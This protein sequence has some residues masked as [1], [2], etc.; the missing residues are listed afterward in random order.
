[1]SLLD[2]VLS[3]IEGVKSVIDVSGAIQG[4]VT[5]AISDGIERAFRKIRK[6]LELSL[7]KV[8]LAFVSMLFIAGGVALII[9]NFMPYRGPGFVMVGALAGIAILLFLHDREEGYPNIR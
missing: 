8:S 6:P 9:D 2:T 4:S 7:M 5:D 1:M 3:F